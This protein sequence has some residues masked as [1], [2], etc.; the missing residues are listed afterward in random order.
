[1]GHDTL[2]L[3]LDAGGTSTRAVLTTSQGECIGYGV[4]GRGNPIA[5]GADLAAE[6]VLDAVALALAPSSRS[7]ADVSVITAAMAGQKAVEGEGGWLRDRLAAEGFAG[8]LTFESDL[9]ATYSSGSVEPFGYAIVAGTGAC[10]VRVSG[11]RIEATADGLG[12][13]L[14]DRG[15]GFWIGR[16]V[17]RAVVRDL[18]DAGPATA[19][20]DAVLERLDIVEDATR[21]EGRSRTLENLVGSLYGVRPIELA[22]LAP[23]AFTADDPVAESIL[24]R[25]GEHLADSFAAVLSG[26]GPLVVGGSVLFRPSEVRDA[27]MQRLGD[28][29]AGLELL[30]VVDGAVGAGVLALRAGGARLSSE[31]HARLCESIERFR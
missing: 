2:M 17:A 24:R 10:A 15:S 18:D 21:R 16:R 12:W 29:A 3:G 1:M 6:G 4:G 14:G 25:A 5:A 28:S 23:L 9:L 27:F 22:A 8:T 26:P 13:L 11:G 7:L 30:P 19:L 20:T 31:T